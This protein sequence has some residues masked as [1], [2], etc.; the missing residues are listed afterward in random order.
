MAYLWQPP[1]NIRD[2]R[3]YLLLSGLPQHHQHRFYSL[4]ILRDPTHSSRRSHQWSGY[5]SHA[6]SRWSR[7]W[8]IHWRCWWSRVQRRNRLELANIRLHPRVR[9]V[10][11]T[12]A[13]A[14]WARGSGRKAPV[15]MSNRMIGNVTGM[16]RPLY[17]VC[18]SARLPGPENATVRL[19]TVSPMEPNHARDPRTPLSVLRLAG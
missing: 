5:E 8:R 2:H 10:L 9:P 13:L 15:A 19:S 7:W 11:W 3:A 12:Q 1:L 18:L 4:P 16:D 17:R 6:R 14:R